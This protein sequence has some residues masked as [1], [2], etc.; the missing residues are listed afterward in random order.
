MAEYS[1]LLRRNRNYRFLW[2][3]NVI[4]LL[5]DWF[6]LLASAQL[7][8]DLTTSGVAISSLFLARFLPL[9]FFSPLAGVLA[10]R[11]DRRRLMIIADL[12]R[13]VTVLGFLLVRSSQQIWLLYLLTVTQFALSALFNPTR[14]AILANVVDRRDLVTANALDSLT[15]STMLAMGAFLG[16]LV[17]ALFGIT[18]AFVADSLTFLI[19]AWAISQVGISATEHLPRSQR[20]PG[21]LDFVDGFRYLRHAPLILGVTLAKGAGT[22]VWGAVNVMEVTIAHQIFPLSIPWLDQFF[23]VEDPGTAT[24]GII[25]VI[26]GLATGMGPLLMRRWLG[27]APSRLFTGVTFSYALMAMGILSIRLATSLPHYLLAALVRGI[28]T[29]TVW[30]FSGTLLQLMVPDRFR[31][32]VFAF[33][34]AVLTLLQSLS[35][36]WAGFAQDVLQLDVKQLATIMGG[37]GLG[38][39]L[40]WILF[41]LAVASRIKTASIS[42]GV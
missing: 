10:D 26:V 37:V 20:R 16:G 15:W 23:R 9:F 17:A 29:G 11:Y 39:L 36:S 8:T 7:V 31:G 21:W 3:G 34:F 24:L 30:V 19:S 22:L 6:N 32:R 35:I 14:S 5:G 13:A 2:W 18:T 38:V 33:D 1:A 41:H 12:L 4:S 25:Y 42:E 40:L 27:D 28:G